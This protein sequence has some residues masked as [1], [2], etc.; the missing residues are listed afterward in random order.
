MLL[1]HGFGNA[2]QGSAG[3]RIPGDARVLVA[4]EHN[5]RDFFSGRVR[6]YPAEQ[7]RARLAMQLAIQ[8]DQGRHGEDRP[9]GIESLA[10]NVIDDLFSSVENGEIATETGLPHGVTE[11]ENIIL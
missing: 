8:K 2:G 3:F 6:A 4:C 10:L 7:S 11:N 1:G 5:D 9:V